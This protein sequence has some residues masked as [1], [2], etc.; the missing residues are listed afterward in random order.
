[1][2]PRP[3]A[4]V[5]VG[6]RGIR[7]VDKATQQ[8]SDPTVT[9][10]LIDQAQRGEGILIWS[11]NPYDWI[12]VRNISALTN[13]NGELV[14]EALRVEVRFEDGLALIRNDDPYKD[15]KLKKLMSLPGWGFT[16]RLLS[17]IH[18]ENK[19]KAQAE[20]I[21]ILTTLSDTDGLSEVL[22]KIAPKLSEEA[23]KVLS[24]IQKLT[25][26]PTEVVEEDKEPE[27]TGLPNSKVVI[28]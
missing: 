18:A 20:A 6:A 3:N 8:L 16:M 25:N 1:M 5:E 7:G 26:K 23:K 9:G 4:N 2:I 12:G 28:S 11:R 15:E 21:K 14:R 19:A 13:A 22:A 27:T 10:G 24:D 17:D